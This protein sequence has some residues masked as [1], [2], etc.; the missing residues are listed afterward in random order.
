MIRNALPVK[1]IQDRGSMELLGDLS[2]FEIFVALVAL[3][4]AGYTAYK[5]FIEGPRIELY[6]GE[7]VTLDS[8]GN[9]CIRIWISGVAINKAAKVGVINPMRVHLKIPTD[10]EVTGKVT[11]F[12]DTSA[13]QTMLTPAY[14][15][16][17]PPHGSKPF[18]VENVYFS[19]RSCKYLDS[20]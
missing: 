15:L 12:V 6:V 4:T 18:H 19:R 7:A 2:I 1:Q 13:Q 9:N 17:V 10:L 3:T 16:S 8:S 11:R 20:R 5:S 14:A